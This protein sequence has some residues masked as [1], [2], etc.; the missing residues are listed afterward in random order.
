MESN[1][2]TVSGNGM[3]ENGHGIMRHSYQPCIRVSL[4]WLDLRVFYVRITKCEIDDS[5]PEY[6]TLNHIPLNHDTLLE[7]NGA[8]TS[9]Y[10][11]NASTLLRRDRLDKKS[12]EVTFVSTDSIRMTGSVKFEVLD[13]DVL[14]L[15]G[16]LELCDSNGFIRESQNHSEKWSMSC[17]SD[18]IA[19]TGFLKG[20]QYTGPESTSPTIEVYVAGCFLDTPIILTKT[21]QFSSRKKQIRKG[22]LDSIPEYEASESHKDVPSGLA[23]QTCYQFTVA[24]RI[25]TVLQFLCSIMV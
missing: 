24:Y 4:P 20:K 10:S 15:H 2:E 22:M 1:H 18:G 14:V 9:I 6:L 11:D 21:L 16:V 12:E 23:L 3:V 8:R 13:K 25:L 5:T 7:V 17:E 19:G